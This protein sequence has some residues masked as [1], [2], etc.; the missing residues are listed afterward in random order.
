MAGLKL[1]L[2]EIYYQHSKEYISPEEEVKGISEDIKGFSEKKKAILKRF[3]NNNIRERDLKKLVIEAL[4]PEN[5]SSGVRAP[6]EVTVQFSRYDSD[7]VKFKKQSGFPVITINL[8]KSLYNS[9]DYKT[10]QNRSEDIIT[11]YKLISEEGKKYFNIEEEK[12]KLKEDV[13]KELLKILSES[14]FKYKIRNGNSGHK[15]ALIDMDKT[16][17]ENISSEFKE[18]YKLLKEVYY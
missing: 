4:K 1:A 12:N 11:V 10:K 3:V 6:I 8:P 18:V 14:G 16:K 15:W 5:I 9:F 7:Q 17:E 13:E 2:Q